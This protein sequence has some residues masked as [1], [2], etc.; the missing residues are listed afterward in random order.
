MRRR[1]RRGT[2]P[3]GGLKGL[4]G[5]LCCEEVAEAELSLLCEDRTGIEPRGLQ[6][7][8]ALRAIATGQLLPHITPELLA[9][10][11]EHLLEPIAAVLYADAPEAEADEEVDGVAEGVQ[12]HLDV[13]VVLQPLLHLERRGQ[14]G[15]EP[16]GIHHL[17]A[18]LEH[19]RHLSV[20]RLLVWGVQES[21]L[22]EDDVEGAIGERPIQRVHRLELHG[23]LQPELSRAEI[24]LLHGLWLQIDA[25][26]TRSAALLGEEQGRPTP[27]AANLEDRLA[28]KVH[29]A[30]DESNLLC[31]AWRDEVLSPKSLPALHG[32][33]GVL[34]LQFLVASAHGEG[35]DDQKR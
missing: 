2:S 32:L 5:R 11:L 8:Q 25:H 35:R 26:N 23:V 22:A 28:R 19:A 21:V 7:L 9:V 33:I 27:A 6:L 16:V 12:H 30:D 4:A 34:E 29:S 31:A 17:A 10:L 20:E 13:A 3:P 24:R 18:G 14:I 15:A 1:L